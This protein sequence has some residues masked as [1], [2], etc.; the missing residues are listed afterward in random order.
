[1]TFVRRQKSVRACPKT[2]KSLA[3]QCRGN[4]IARPPIVWVFSGIKL[5]TTVSY[6]NPVPIR[7]GCED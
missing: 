1:M 5:T 2:E 3:I 6:L 7:R 4:R